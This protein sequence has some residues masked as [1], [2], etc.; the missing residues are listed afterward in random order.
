VL[1]QHRHAGHEDLERR[2]GGGEFCADGG[3]VYFAEFN[4]F[5]AD[6]HHIL[7]GVGDV[8]VVEAFEGEEHIVGGDGSAVGPFQALAQLEC[9]DGL[10]LLVHEPLLEQA[11][12]ELLGAQVEPDEA[13]V[14]EAVDFVRAA[15]VGGDGVEILGSVAECDKDECAAAGARFDIRDEFGVRKRQ[16]D[17]GLGGGRCGAVFDAHGL[18]IH[19]NV[20]RAHGIHRGQGAGGRLG[21]LCAGG[22]LR[23]VAT[24][25]C[26]HGGS[27]QKQG[28]EHCRV[29]MRCS[30]DAHCVHATH[31]LE[32]DEWPAAH[33]P[34]GAC[35]QTP[36]GAT[37]GPSDASRLRLRGATVPGRPGGR[38][39]AG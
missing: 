26:R 35:R 33:A 28:R 25:G 19:G 30:K 12:L 22:R 1:G 5:S 8:G 17:G 23:G 31:P 18:E 11:G 39:C 2:G 16:D 21:R 36:N 9:P 24:G 6:L 10:I 32:D 14:H 37:R 13:G 20:P 4:G 34:R 7:A 3:V 15:V 29:F 27:G 38:A